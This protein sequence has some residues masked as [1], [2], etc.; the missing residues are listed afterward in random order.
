MAFGMYFTPASFTREQ[1]DQ[2]ITK[3]EAAGAG[4]PASEQQTF[5]GRVG[6]RPP[7]NVGELGDDVGWV[8]VLD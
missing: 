8:A 6:D 2:A 7:I 4:A 5:V 1:Y 3:L